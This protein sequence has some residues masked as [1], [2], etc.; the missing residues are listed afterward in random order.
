MGVGGRQP[1]S[2]VGETPNPALRATFPLALTPHILWGPLPVGEGGKPNDEHPF[3]QLDAEHSSQLTTDNWQLAKDNGQLA[4]LSF[5]LGWFAR[6]ILWLFVGIGCG[7][8]VGAF[9]PEHAGR[10]DPRHVGLAQ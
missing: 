5:L 8:L 3:L 9:F 1:C 6:G 2:V 10:H 7:G 4:T